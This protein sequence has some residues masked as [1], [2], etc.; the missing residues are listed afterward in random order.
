MILHD[1]STHTIAEIAR[2]LYSI[3]KEDLFEIADAQIAILE[4]TN[5]PA[6]ANA[7]RVLKTFG[8][9]LANGRNISIPKVLN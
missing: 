8:L 1:I 5:Y 7:W 2:T 4:S 3:H 6:A 9:D